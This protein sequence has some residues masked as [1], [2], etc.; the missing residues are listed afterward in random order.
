MNSL[1]P[2]RSTARQIAFQFIFRFDSEK[3]KQDPTPIRTEMI[4]HFQHFQTPEESRDF[5]LR[6]VLTTLQNLPILDQLAVQNLQN[7]RLERVGA[8][9]RAL[10]RMGIAELLYFK[11]VPASVTLD[12]VIELAKHFGND[13]S[14][15]FLNGVLD[16]I[17]KLPE[18]TTGKVASNP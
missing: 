18:V 6:L 13:E 7:W 17:S 1:P 11:D 5:A 3:E 4:L 15:S 16:P 12:E 8:V 10:L 2:T 9:E 14:A